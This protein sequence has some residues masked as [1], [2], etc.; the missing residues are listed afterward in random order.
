M[1]ERR[2]AC[3]QL[4][5]PRLPLLP[6]IRNIILPLTGSHETV[7]VFSFL[8]VNFLLYVFIFVPSSNVFSKA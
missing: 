2:D 4:I 8:F 7:F 6:L 5:Q 1:S 3:T